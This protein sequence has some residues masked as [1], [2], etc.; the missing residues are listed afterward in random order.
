M[1]I[2]CTAAILADLGGSVVI[3]MCNMQLVL[4]KIYHASCYPR[5]GFITNRRVTFPGWI[6][7]GNARWPVSDNRNSGE[8]I[9]RYWPTRYRPPIER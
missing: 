3:V 5:S 1:G 9:G 6:G 2:H 7:P 8:S 4:P